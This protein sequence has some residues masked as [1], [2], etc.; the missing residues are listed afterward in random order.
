MKVLLLGALVGIV[1]SV[2]I[3]V[4]KSSLSVNNMVQSEVHFNTCDRKEKYICEYM[5]IKIWSY[6]EYGSTMFFTDDVFEDSGSEK[7]FFIECNNLENLKLSIDLLKCSFG[8][9]N[10]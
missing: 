7:L 4:I 2:S 8:T 1:G 5:G 9:S 6:E 10:N 3:F